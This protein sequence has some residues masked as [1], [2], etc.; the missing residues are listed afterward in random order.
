VFNI[1]CI[2]DKKCVEERYK[3]KNEV[4]E[5]PEDAIAEIE[6]SNKKAEKLRV[7]VEQ[8]FIAG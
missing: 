7:E 8:T 4:E 3:K 1:H 5:L 2:C 6:D